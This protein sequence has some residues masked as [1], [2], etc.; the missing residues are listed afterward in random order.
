MGKKGPACISILQ[1]R[2]N[3]SISYWFSGEAFY[4]RSYTTDDGLTV[5]HG[6]SFESAECDYSI[7]NPLKEPHKLIIWANKYTP[8]G[9]EIKLGN[10]EDGELLYSG[11]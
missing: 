11:D 2:Q 6:S 9:E 5:F 3:N 4:A 1:L 10:C 7:E 8:R